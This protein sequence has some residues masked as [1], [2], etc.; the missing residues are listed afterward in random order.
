MQH[1]NLFLIEYLVKISIPTS[2]NT[3]SPT[4]LCCIQGLQTPKGL[5]SLG[6]LTHVKYFLTKSLS[7]C[8][9]QGT[10]G[11]ESEPVNSVE[12]PLS[13][14]CDADLYPQTI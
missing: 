4:Q 10:K 12:V 5:A 8:G 14:G 6:L 3:L 1:S 13:Q 7:S 2:L 9:S 11:Q